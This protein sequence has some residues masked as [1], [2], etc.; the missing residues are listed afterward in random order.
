MK[1]ALS[2]AGTDPSGGAGMH[3]DLKTFAAHKVYGMGA[4]TAVVAQNTRG[5][6]AIEYVSPRMIEAQ[7]DAVFGDIMPDAVKVGMLGLPASAAAVARCLRRYRPRFV[8]VDPVMVSSSGRRLL[9][10]AAESTLRDEILPRA[11][12]VTPN[13]GEAEVLAG[14]PVDGRASMERAAEKIAALGCAAV[15]VKGG[16]SAGDCDDYLLSPD[17]SGWFHSPRI[18]TK[19]THGTGCTLSAAIAANLA[20]G[21]ALPEAVKRGKAYLTG[22][23]SSG[24]ELGGGAGPL[25]HSWSTEIVGF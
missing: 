5:V 1:T 16:H 17:F 8:V 12:L 13:I 6:Y 23:L 4:V 14:F 15:L 2:I 10:T 7:L 21:F 9:D 19:N 22:A 18:P 3:A 11:C 20:F 24:L 25:E